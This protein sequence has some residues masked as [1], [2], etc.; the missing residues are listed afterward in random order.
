MGFM[1][2]RLEGACIASCSNK[3]QA[4][5]TRLSIFSTMAAQ[6]D[7]QQ[8]SPARDTSTAS[9]ANAIRRMGALTMSGA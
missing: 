8:S 2:T 3:A 9:G 1:E 6:L 7:G 4:T 5:W